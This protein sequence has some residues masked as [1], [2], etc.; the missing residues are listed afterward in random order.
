[1]KIAI[2][3]T[4]P[5]SCR[6]APYSDPAW[7]IWGCS[8]GLYPVAPRTN[9]WFEL[10]RWEPPVIGKPDQ[11][12]AWFSPEYVAWLSQYQ[13]TVWVSDPNA[14]A[15]LRT[16]KL[17]PWQELVKKYGHYFMT[18]SI[19]WMMA[20]AIDNI[21]LERERRAISGEVSS[22]PDMIGLWGVDM[23][24]GEEYGYQR[25][26][27]Q[28]FVS[29]AMS[30]G[31]QVIVPAESDLL[32]PAPLYGVSETS[33]KSIKLLARSNELRGRIAQVEAQIQAAT[34]NKQWLQGALEDNE[35][36]AKTWITEGVPLCTD[37]DGVLRGAHIYGPDP[38][39]RA[40][41]VAYLN[42]RAVPGVLR[43]MGELE[44]LTDDQLTMRYQQAVAE[45]QAR[46]AEQPAA[47]V[48]PKPKKRPKRK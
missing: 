19:A 7:L 4:A 48:V 6:L 5:A 45:D 22:E 2:L 12:K 37:F 8:P 3:G 41:M 42:A 38:K 28:F 30:R 1:M 15:D 40:E 20:M 46:P 14:L 16:G 18:S 23:S 10:H 44:T 9:A 47:P 34:A 36:H 33:P 25:A 31:I 21:E 27:C 39:P 29:L 24:A 11:Q 32:C 26:G 43:R 13:G 35:Y 17:L